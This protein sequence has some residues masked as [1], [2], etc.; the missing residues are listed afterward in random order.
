MGRV[1]VDK[2][3]REGCSRNLESAKTLRGRANPLHIGLICALLQEEEGACLLVLRR[4]ALY[5]GSLNGYFHEPSFSS[6]HRL[7]FQLS[8]S[9]CSTSSW[10]RVETT[11]VVDRLSLTAWTSRARISSFASRASGR[12]FLFG[13]RRG[14]L[15]RL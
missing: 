11:G 2:Q 3:G 9:S 8:S 10:E 6:P 14:S 5:G 13:V 1:W 12:A 7:L 4:S 15:V